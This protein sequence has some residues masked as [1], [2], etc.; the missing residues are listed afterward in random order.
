MGGAGFSY[1]LSPEPK[2]LPV[3]ETVKRAFE[4]G[5]RA[6]DTSPYYEPSEELLGAALSHPDI[7]SKFPRSDLV[8]MTKCGRI[9]E[10]HFDYSPRWIRTSVAR[11]LQ[12]FKTPYL[13]VVFCHDVEF[14]TLAEAIEAVGILFELSKAGVV[15]NVGISGYKIDVLLNVAAAVRRKY[16]RPVD[17]V[18]NWAQLTLQNTRLEREGLAAFRSLGVKAVCNASPLAVGLLR[19]GGVPIAALGDWHPAPQGLRAS[20]QEASA[21]VQ[22]QGDNLASLAL[23]FTMSRAMQNT[24]PGFQVSTITGISSIQDLEQNVETA[25]GILATEIFKNNESRSKMEQ[26]LE[27]FTK[28]DLDTSTR[29]LPLYQGVRNIL[30]PWVDYDFSAPP[31]QTPTTAQN[32]LD[33]Q[34]VAQNVSSRL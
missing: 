1:Q 28:L 29:D 11:S 18:Q 17:V 6:I 24:K 10:N 21:W 4:L 34:P 27:F 19:S 16:G 23:R 2:S 14:V 31:M 3:L 33:V 8:I 32:V 9:A 12:R 13:D 20:A 22:G 25:K 30:G 5:L 15:R 26:N 7:V